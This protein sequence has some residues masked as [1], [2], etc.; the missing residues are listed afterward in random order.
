M[1]LKGDLQL[2]IDN[3]LDM[4]AK[5]TQEAESCEAAAA[6][7]YNNSI[8]VAK[9]SSDTAK[10]LRADAAYHQAEADYR[11]EQQAKEVWSGSL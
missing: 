11:M 3:E 10:R 9:A 6:L 8:W 5:S 7:P 4:A 1:W 2:M